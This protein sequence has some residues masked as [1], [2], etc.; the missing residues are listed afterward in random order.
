M[1]SS[2]TL[3]ILIPECQN[4]IAAEEG[5]EG[6]CVL[7]DN[8]LCVNLRAVMLQRHSGSSLFKMGEMGSAPLA[9]KIQCQQLY[10]Q[11]PEMRLNLK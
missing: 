8:A 6:N 10:T 5:R 2:D 3:D 1:W 4:T 9:T 7:V 11:C